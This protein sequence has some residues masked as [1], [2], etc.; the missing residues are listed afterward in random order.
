MKYNITQAAAIAQVTRKTFR[1]HIKKKGITVEKDDNGNP[2]VDASELA[3]VYGDQCKFPNLNGDK[4]IPISEKIFTEIP[5]KDVAEMALI[6]KELELVKEQLDTQRDDFE[7]QIDYLQVKLDDADSHTRKLT[8]I[9]TDQRSEK[10][11][12]ETSWEQSMKALEHRVSNQAK[13]TAEKQRK[14]LQQNR[15]LQKALF[16]ERNKSIWQRL[17]GQSRKT[18]TE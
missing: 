12:Q 1:S 3:R 14:L 7:K 8:A 10:E 11:K 13:E 18:N 9:L 4:S 17:F 15:R 16:E 6:K 2:L 5:V